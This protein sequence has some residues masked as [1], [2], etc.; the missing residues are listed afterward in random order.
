[1]AIQWADDFSRYG[2]GTAS[3]T[4]MLDG[5][6]YAIIRGNTTEGFVVADP[7]PNGDGSPVFRVGAST[8]NWE[9][10]FRIALPT[11]SDGEIGVLFRAW[12]SNLPAGGGGDRP[13][14][15][16]IQNAGGNYIL[17]LRIEPNGSVTTHGRVGGSITQ[18]ADSI[19]PIISPNSYNHYELVHDTGTGEGELFINGVSRLSWTGVSNDFDAALVNF[20]RRTS[21]S[22]SGPAYFLKDL[23]IWDDEGTENNSLMG[24]VVVRRLSPN[25]DVTLGGWLPSTGSTGFNLLAKGVPNDATFLAGDDSPPAAMEF[26]LQGLPDDVTS[27][28]GLIAVSRHRKVDG[29]DANLQVSLTPNGTDWALG[30]DRPI[31]TTFQYDFDVFELNPDTGQPWTPVDT[32]SVVARIDRTT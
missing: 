31:T 22:G 9:T 10:D 7:D 6:P 16:G 17:Y 14:F 20:S 13:A 30:A 11:V 8:N 19:N 27:V 5:L 12:F 21:P 26:G 32:D 29:G 2:T 4:A 24:T 25:V 18:V 23:V 1:M 15:V 3:R 28:R